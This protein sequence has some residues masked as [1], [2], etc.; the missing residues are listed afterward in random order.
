[1]AKHPKPPGTL[2]ER[3]QALWREIV[4]RRA[5]S[6]GRLTLLEQALL[7]LDRADQ[8]AAEL[9]GK[10]LTTTTEKTGAVHVHPAVKIEREGRQQFA[11]LWGQ[12][13]LSWD[14]AVDGWF[15]NHDEDDE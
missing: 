14:E 2:S 10:S 12:L 9:A 1:M 4:P 8:A 13:N 3:S 6:I 11:K 15:A 5:K 7:A